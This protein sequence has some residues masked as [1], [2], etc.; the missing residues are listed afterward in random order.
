MQKKSDREQYST[1]LEQLRYAVHE[2]PAGVLY[3]ADGATEK[4][5]AEW[6]QDLLVFEQLCERLNNDH[7]AFI[8][9]CRWHFEHYPHYLGRR[10]H[11]TSYEQ[12]TIERHG[13]LKVR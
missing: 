8:E 3:G 10:R 11:F 5:C 2:L 13:P 1:L 6:M 4:Q 9:G 12:Y 7:R